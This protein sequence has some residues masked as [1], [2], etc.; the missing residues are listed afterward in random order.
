MSEDEDRNDG[1]SRVSGDGVQRF[2][3]REHDVVTL[4]RIGNNR[5]VLSGC[6]DKKQ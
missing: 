1:V 2:H 6:C 5:A 4:V 3:R